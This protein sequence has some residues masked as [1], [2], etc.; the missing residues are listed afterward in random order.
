MHLI[1]FDTPV[2]RDNLKPFTFTRPMAEIRVGILTIAEKWRKRLELHAQEHAYITET[3]L[4]KKYP[5]NIADDNLLINA[6]VCPD[7]S[8][9]KAVTQLASGH[10][11]KQGNLII[12]ARISADALRA[13]DNHYALSFLQVH[14]QLMN[15]V[16]AY[17]SVQYTESLTLITQPWHIFLQ[18]GEQIKVDFDLLTQNRKSAAIADPY[19]IVY[20]NPQ[21]IFIEEGVSVRASILNA[22]TGPIYLGKNATIHEN[23]VIKGPFAMLEGAHV[24]IGSKIREATTIGPHSKLGGEVKNVVVFGNSN[25]GH[26]GFLGNS[27]IGE[28]CNF[29]ADT[30]ASNLKNNYKHVSMWNYGTHR[31]EDTGELFCGLMMGDHSKCGINTMF[32]TG[33]VVGVFANIF[34]TGYPEKFIPSFSWGGIGESSIYQIEKA[35]EVAHHVLQRRGL[36]LSEAEVDILKH[37]Y[38]YR[39]SELEK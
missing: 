37:I 21:N 4:Q 25:K 1:F 24:N 15:R 38:E 22:E 27:V 28:W 6:S 39:S 12:A 19:T 35:L 26:E 14:E 5:F 11:L 20:G 36:Q 2:I 34:G 3:Y 8:V 10:I 23:A 33:T 7:I 31:Y 13:L 29:G 16:A 17:P 30:N 9:Q 18:N 32:N